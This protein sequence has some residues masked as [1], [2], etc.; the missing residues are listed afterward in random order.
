M[1]EEKVEKIDSRLKETI[2]KY[3]FKIK[4]Y[5]EKERK[6]EEV[7]SEGGRSLRRRNSSIG[8]SLGSITDLEFSDDRLSLKRWVN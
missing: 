3:E 5:E 6:H 7:K 2:D 8:S 1:L 4:F